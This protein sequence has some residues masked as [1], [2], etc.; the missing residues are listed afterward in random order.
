MREIEVLDQSQQVPCLLPSSLPSLYGKGKFHPIPCNQQA[1]ECYKNGWLA[2]ENHR[3]GL[4]L[5]AQKGEPP[6]HTREVGRAGLTFVWG[7]L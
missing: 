1:T 3:Q 2:R 4:P 7:R 6:T 5:C